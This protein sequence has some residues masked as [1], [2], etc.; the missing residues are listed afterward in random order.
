MLSPRELVMHHKLD[1]A[2]HCKAPFKSYCK[3]HDKPVP[4]NMMVSRTSPAIILGPTGNIQGTYKLLN[5]AMGNKIKHHQ[6]TACPMPDLVIKKVEAMGKQQLPGMFDFSDRNGVLFEWNEDV[7]EYN[8]NIVKEDVIL[9]PS[10]AAE[11]PGVTLDRNVAVPSINE[12]VIPH[13]LAEDATAQNANAAPFVAQEWING[14]A[15]IHAN[16]NEIGEYNNKDN[17]IIEVA[18]IPPECPPPEP[19]HRHP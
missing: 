10:L 15:A 16:N 13:S 17:G 4:S 1:F 12:E 11:F 2:K 9:Y 3:S 14:L 19:H 6:F 8:E 18:N 5:L 7:D